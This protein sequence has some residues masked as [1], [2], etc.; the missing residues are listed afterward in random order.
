MN[1]QVRHIK[2]LVVVISLLA[3][4]LVSN[5]FAGKVKNVTFRVSTPYPPPEQSLATKHLVTWQQMVTERT[6]GAVKFTNFFGGSLGKASE[7]LDLVS[8]G[9]ADIVVTYGWYTPSKLPLEDFDYIFPF[10]PTDP[11]ILTRAMRQIN[12]EFPQFA[13]DFDKH[14][15]VKIF[16]SP[17][18][19]EVFLSKEPIK[20][21]EDFQGK[22]CK[23]IGRYFGRWIEALNAVPVA[24]PGTEVYTMLQTGVIDTALDTADLQYAYNNIEQAPHV[25]DPGLLTTNWI[26]CWINKDSLAKLNKD[27]QNILLR[28]GEELEI[29]ASLE[30]NPIWEANIFDTWEKLDTYTF[31]VMSDADRKKWAEACP[32]TPAEWADEVTKL[33]YPGWDILNRYVEIT[34]QY[35]HQWL[36]DYTKK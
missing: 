18:I 5:S 22:K 30:I 33:G 29:K 6:N 32:N 20:K 8:T 10:G 35:G 28:S 16:Q 3:I 36:R 12:F 15:I 17:G 25:L 1:L 14:N 26:G 11:Y 2:L 13:K 34:T 4:S 7:H 24:A 31:S 21:Y 27:Q 9:T 23:V 19:K